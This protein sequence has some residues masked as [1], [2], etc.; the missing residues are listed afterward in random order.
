MYNV[1]VRFWVDRSHSS[2]SIH[3]SE[4]GVYGAL[5]MLLLEAQ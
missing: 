1:R 4:G 3:M 2:M 5:V